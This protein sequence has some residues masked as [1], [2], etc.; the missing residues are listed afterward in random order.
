MYLSLVGF[1]SAAKR[2]MKINDF[3][4]FHVKTKVVM[5][6]EFQSVIFKFKEFIYNVFPPF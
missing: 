1:D 3:K 5:K 6:T 4:F 2:N